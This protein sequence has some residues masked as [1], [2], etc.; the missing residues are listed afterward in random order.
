MTGLELIIASILATLIIEI[1]YFVAKITLRSIRKWIS[2]RGTYANKN[3]IGFALK[4]K[5]RNGNYKVVPGVF[6]KRTD[7]VV[8]CKGYETK[9]IDRHLAEE[10]DLTIYN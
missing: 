3:E 1:I 8:E 5:M 4:E 6:N 10:E 9:N 2:Q 7:E